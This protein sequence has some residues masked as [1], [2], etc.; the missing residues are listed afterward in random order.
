MPNLL[1]ILIILASLLILAILGIFAF[2]ICRVFLIKKGHIKQ[3]LNMSLF[4]IRVPRESAPAQGQDKKTEKESIS[5]MEQLYS[6][7][8]NLSQCSKIKNWIYGPPHVALEIAIESMGEE[9]GFYLSLPRWLENT[10]EK[11][12]HGFFP[13]AEIIKQKEYNIF[14]ANGKEAIAYLRLRKRGILPIRTYQKLETDPLGELTTALSKIDNPGEGA[15][16]QI[17]LRPA[18]K[19][20]TSNAQKVMEQINKGENIGKAL[21][22]LKLDISGISQKALQSAVD[23]PG[24]FASQSKQASQHDAQK[25]D[26]QTPEPVKL[27]PIQEETIKSIQE[28]TSKPGF[29]TILRLVASAESQDQAD[30][31]LGHLTSA[32][33]QFSAPQANS[34]KIIKAKP[35]H[36][37][38]HRISK[39]KLLYHFIFRIFHEKHAFILNTEEIASI[40][41]F[42]IYSTKTPKLKLL[43]S[44]QAPSPANMPQTGLILGKNNFRGQKTLVRLTKEDRRRHLYVIGQ[45]GT[46][47]SSQIKELVR[48]DIESGHGIG[49]IDPHGELIDDILGYVPANR[50]EDVILFNPS[51]LERPI[52]LNMLEYDPAKPEQ[53]T[54]IVNELINIF[55]KLYDLKTT[56]G[57]M[58]EQY[59][60]NALL[61]LMDDPN[62]PVTLMEVPKVLADAD[63]RKRLLAKCKDPIVRNFWEKEAEKAGGDAALANMVPYITSKFNIF[64]AN[65]YMRPII[66]QVKTG[67]KFREI[68]DSK[69]ILLI[70]LSKGKLGDINSSLLGLIIVSKIMIAAFARADTPTEQRSDFYFYLDEFQNFTTPSIATI[71]SEA[72]KYHLNLII[73][74][75]FIGQLQEEIKKAVFGNVGNL[76]TMR[77]GAEDAEF[78]VKQYEPVFTQNDLV[79]I[80]NFNSFVKLQIAGATTEAFSMEHVK[81]KE[82]NIEMADKIR[83]LARLKFG[84]AREQ[85]KEEIRGRS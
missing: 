50:A 76:I 32:F 28:K 18:H 58:F 85:V 71:L 82:S 75:Q 49:V 78:L 5:I 52:G 8:A 20:W 68:M 65:D 46:G 6:S 12:I 19:K 72:R 10:I 41:H 15:A 67:L 38:V 4:L 66:G 61:L 31:L 40:F 63:Y 21:G 47:K 35:K 64:I 81:P 44:I 7:L 43:K 80:N 74:H 2:L 27:T 13:K 14:N 54:F 45:T 83:E 22:E 23:L 26:Q 84:K 25:K 53:K 16:I 11:Q 24:S 33:T 55:D 39:R 60:R 79:N 62:E 51:D 70:N 3:S 29:S 42:P 1:T 57:P 9:I 30:Q 73:A 69:K 48:Q 17:I 36:K 77:V 37:A 34:F 59:T 56:G